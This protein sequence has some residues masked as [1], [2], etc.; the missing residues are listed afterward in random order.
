MSSGGNLSVQRNNEGLFREEIFRSSEAVKSV[1][2]LVVESLDR[3][4]VFLNTFLAKV[5]GVCLILM[6][7]TVVLNGIMRVVYEPFF[8]TAEV[9]G[10]LCA[11]T[12]SFSLGY[13]QLKRGY[14]EM[15][16]FLNKLSSKFRRTVKGFMLFASAV[17]FSL[18]C[19]Q[20]IIYS[21][22]VLKN[23]NVSETIGISFYPLIFFAALG[24][25]GLSLALIVDFLKHIIGG[26]EG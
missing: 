18:V 4:S 2:L 14:V 20:I 24:F 22:N 3:I 21:I 8:G 1:P 12:T 17:F 10:W 16:M 6:M 26:A 9:V 5:A 13:T 25:A 19:W 7:F 15:D 11:L 23:G